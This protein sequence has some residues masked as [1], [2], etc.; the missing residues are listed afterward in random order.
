MN[1]QSVAS[2]TLAWLFLGLSGCASPGLLK[3]AKS[4]YPKSGPKNPVVRIL[5]VWEPAMGIGLDDK[6]AR[7]FSG[8]IYFFSQG[9]DLAAKV[10]GDVRVYVFDDVGSPEEQMQPLHEA[11]FS[12]DAWNALLTKGPLGA[13]YNVFVP[14]IR[15]GN[16][17][18]K[19]TLRIRY[20]P[21]S[22][23][24]AYSD[25]VNICLEGRKKPGAKREG[26]ETAA[27]PGV[28]SKSSSSL[29]NQMAEAAV[30][31]SA[32]V[33]PRA[34]GLA[35]A[36]TATLGPDALQPRRPS[37]VALTDQERERIIR[38]VRARMK[39]ETNGTIALAAYDPDGESGP[40]DGNQSS[41]RSPNPLQEDEA[42][43]EGL[44]DSV[45]D[46]DVGEPEAPIRTIRHRPNSGRRHILAETSWADD[47][48]ETS[49]EDDLQADPDFESHLPDDAQ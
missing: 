11:N 8:Q 23:P 35:E 34:R 29:P 36:I 49:I 32:K 5:G 7:G 19:C 15:P 46:G 13:T 30:P 43:E 6:S 44:D 40:A 27:Q 41:K 37:A 39:A 38:E 33:P 4:D 24:I 26:E 12:A 2:L 1:V 25:F 20:K 9:S 48:G 21:A 14:Y 18:A 17:E 28:R 47:D 42:A 10:D 22:G 3:M 16:F 45:A 31:G